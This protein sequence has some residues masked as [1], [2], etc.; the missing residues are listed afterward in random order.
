MAQI[1]S[2]DQYI[3]PENTPIHKLQI[4]DA[5]TKLNDQE[6]KYAHYLSQA[7]WQ[8]SRIC[9]FQLSPESPILFE[10]FQN[11]FSNNRVELL[12]ESSV[13]H[14]VS[15]ADFDNFLQYVAVFYGNMGNYLSFGDTK[16]IPRIPK[17]KFQSLLGSAANSTVQ[18]QAL[19]NQCKARVYSLSIQERE[20]GLEDKGISTYYSPNIT[21][22][23]ISNV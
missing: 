11:L 13:K 1:E 17:E 12:R 5:F 7:S 14:G 21:R 18:I 22:A 19:W 23:E 15:R 3:T 20:L 10:L 16:F 9:L 6:R 4:A 8:G 2:I